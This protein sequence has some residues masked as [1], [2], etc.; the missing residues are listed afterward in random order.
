MGNM[1]TPR[2]DIYTGIHKALRARLFETAHELSGCNFADPTDRAETLQHLRATLAFLDEH[3]EHED[4][5]V[6][7]RLADANPQLAA[8][9]ADGHQHLE[10]TSATVTRLL[11]AITD[12]NADLA[13]E[14]GPELYRAYNQ[15]VGEHLVHMNEEETVVNAALWSAYT[16]EQL[17]ELHGAIQGSIPPARFAEWLTIMLPALNLQEQV[18]MMTGMRAAAPPEVFANVMAAGRAAVGPRWGAVESALG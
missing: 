14:R 6:Q 1:S 3:L 17:L 12:A 7:P 5:H 4:T 16:D 11:A 18:G 10:Q 13:V 2:H 9:I 15:L 8:R